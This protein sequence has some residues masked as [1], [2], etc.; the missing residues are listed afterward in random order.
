MVQRHSQIPKSQYTQIALSHKKQ[1]IENSYS[2]FKWTVLNKY[3]IPK[4]NTRE[5]GEFPLVKLPIRH[6]RTHTTPSKK[7]A[8]QIQRSHNTSTKLSVETKTKGTTK[9]IFDALPT[10]TK[11]TRDQQ[12]YPIKY[13]V[14]RVATNKEREHQNKLPHNHHS[15]TLAATYIYQRVVIIGQDQKSRSPIFLNSNTMHN[16]FKQKYNSFRFAIHGL[17]NISSIR[18][19]ISKSGVTHLLMVVISCGNVFGEINSSQ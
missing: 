12:K 10:Q 2:L 13:A 7:A 1:I 19:P 16:Q 4:S 17:K 6:Q 11:V 14:P 5:I 18:T 15:S 8:P 9:Q 3:Q